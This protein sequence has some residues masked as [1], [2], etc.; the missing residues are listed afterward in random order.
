MNL[1]DSSRVSL[2]PTHCPLA[3]DHFLVGI[4]VPSCCL[5]KVKLLSSMTFSQN[6]SFH[7]SL[8]NKTCN[9]IV[10]TYEFTCKNVSTMS[11]MQERLKKYWLNNYSMNECFR[12]SREKKTATQVWCQNDFTGHVVLLFLHRYRW[13]QGPFSWPHSAVAFSFIVFSQWF[14]EF[15]VQLFAD[16]ISPPLNYNFHEG[17]CLVCHWINCL[18]SVFLAQS[19]GR[20]QYS[21]FTGLVNI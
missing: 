16:W 6:F 12:L 7:R 19:I 21:I 10:E 8:I 15:F 18:S 4:H 20:A 9:R 3:S 2:C 11:G 14:G 1:S 13:G 17:V 5:R